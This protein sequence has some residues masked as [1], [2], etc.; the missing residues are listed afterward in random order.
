MR[1]WGIC[2][3]CGRKQL[4]LLSFDVSIR[5]W[6][7]LSIG[8]AIHVFVTRA[9]LIQIGTITTCV[10][11]NFT[12]DDRHVG[13]YTLQVLPTYIYMIKTR[14]FQCT[15]DTNNTATKKDVSSLSAQLVETSLPWRYRQGCIL[16]I[17]PCK[18]KWSISRDDF[19]LPM[20]ESTY[21]STLLTTQTSSGFHPHGRYWFPINE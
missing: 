4:L 7:I 20:V 9:N 19:E 10:E 21:L 14:D 11:Y 16:T 15:P 13:Y 5:L 12:L 3:R 18:E 8:T 17:G 2:S 6:Y 1:R